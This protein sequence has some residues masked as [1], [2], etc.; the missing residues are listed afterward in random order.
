LSE[1]ITIGGLPVGGQEPLLSAA[2]RWGDV[3]YLSGRAAVDPATL[4]VT[5]QD[6][7]EQTRLVLEEVVGVLRQGG[8]GPEH[9][10]RVVCY[11]ADRSHFS[12]WN[13]LYAE[14]FP[15]PRP[16]RTTMVADFAVEGLLIE[17]EVTAGIPT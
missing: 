8:S 11:L 14:Y 1:K 9:A 16:A 13:R 6:F 2:V 12:A 7:E 5:S 10:L 4:K 15:A 3:L 17:V